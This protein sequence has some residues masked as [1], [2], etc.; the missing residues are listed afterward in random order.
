MLVNW[1]FSGHVG[2]RL[3]ISCCDMLVIIFRPLRKPD[4]ISAVG[5]I[6]KQYPVYPAGFGC[7]DCFVELS[8]KF[9]LELVS[10]DLKLMKQ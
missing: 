10:S 6:S 8:A 3:S 2:V 9:L 5:Q 1:H 4:L 7:C